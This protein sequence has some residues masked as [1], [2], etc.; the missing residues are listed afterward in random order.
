MLKERDFTNSSVGPSAA[1]SGSGWASS[2]TAL[3]FALDR[4]STGVSAFFALELARDRLAGFSSDSESSESD[5]S[6]LFFLAA[7]FLGACFSSLSLSLSSEESEPLAA[8][9]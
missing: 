3:E 5:E 2:L 4:F 6:S 1:A 8:A 9:F 7:A